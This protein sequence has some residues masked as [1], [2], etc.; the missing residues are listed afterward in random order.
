M[1]DVISDICVALETTGAIVRAVPADAW[2][3][4]TPCSSWNVHQVTNH[5]VG[6]MRIF[7]GELTGA[8]A[9]ADHDSDWLDDDPAAA[10]N[11][12]AVLDR[13]AWSRPDALAGTVTIGLGTLPSPLAAVIHLTEVVVHGLD[14]AVGINR[15]DLV[16]EEQCSRLLARMRDMGGV[17]AY[18]TPGVFGAEMPAPSETS[19]RIQLLAYLGR[20]VAVRVQT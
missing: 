12:A 8:P 14:I 15:V 9:G 5:V 6:G 17:D 1:N 18:R 10:Y 19:P 7:A 16:D 4:S 3:H 20:D 13:A 11:A 2:H